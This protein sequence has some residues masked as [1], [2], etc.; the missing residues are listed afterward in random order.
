MTRRMLMVSLCVAGVGAAGAVAISA[1]MEAPVSDQ[2]RLAS[3]PV[4]V[5]VMTRGPVLVDLDDDG[6]LDVVV[7]CGPCCGA[8]PHPDAGHVMVLRN[9]G[10]GV[11]SPVGGRI[12][13]GETALGVDVGDVNHDGI[14]DVVVHHHSSYEVAVLIGVG[15]G[16]FSEPRYVTLHDGESP[17]VHSIRLA[18]VNG[19]GHADVLATLVDDHAL[20]VLLG[21]GAGGFTPA[22]G[23]PY[24]AH[25]HPYSQL[26]VVDINEDG[27]LDAIMTDMRGGG[28]TVLV[29]SGTG[30]FASSNG[31]LLEAHTPIQLAERPMAC[32]LGDLDGD[33]DLDA[34]A[35]FDESPL[36]VQMI[37]EGKGVFVEPDHAGVVLSDAS[38]GGRLAD[39]DG[40]GNL[41]FVASTTMTE[42]VS[43]SP[44]KGDGT[45][46][47]PYRVRAHGGSPSAAVGDMNGDGVMDLVTGNSGS[48]TVSVL[49]QR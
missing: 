36:A 49:L 40:D 42:Y 18:D 2:F 43:V 13:V 39:V 46:G 34:V 11:L 1:A 4:K 37:N 6:D 45:F 22:L 12:K 31:F 20:A 35:V 17:H 3:E 27:H 25:R 9:D 24:F 41:D 16:V 38:T 28:M 44:G 19:D 30:M 47:A 5:G 21:D 7:P 23:Q 32:T 29:G 33:G 15:G 14:V 10:S 48:G 26:N 8:D